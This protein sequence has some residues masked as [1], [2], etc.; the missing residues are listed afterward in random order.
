MVCGA[1]ALALAMSAVAV[2]SASLPAVA[3]VC[4]S[5]WDWAWVIPALADAEPAAA[6][7]SRAGALLWLGSVGVVGGLS[8]LACNLASAAF[9]VQSES[10]SHWATCRRTSSS[11][12]LV[13][14]LLSLC[15]R[16]LQAC[17]GCVAVAATGE[18]AAAVWR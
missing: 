12:L 4:S 6:T 15:F 10:A 7:K 3:E 17:C 16:L 13:S 5:G 2:A 14:E 1:L 8:R 9:L 18:S 11:S